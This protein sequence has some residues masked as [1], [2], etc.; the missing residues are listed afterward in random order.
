MNTVLEAIRL[1]KEIGGKE[2]LNC[3]AELDE[4]AAAGSI[5]R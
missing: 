2:G 1:A 3:I 5:L 4:T